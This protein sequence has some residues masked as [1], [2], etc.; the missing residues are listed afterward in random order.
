[1]CGECCHA[2][3]D[4]AWMLNKKEQGKGG[5]TGLALYAANRSC[6][7]FGCFDEALHSISRRTRLIGVNGVK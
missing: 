2:H 5:L 4:Q 6:Y 1:M 3:V 7:P